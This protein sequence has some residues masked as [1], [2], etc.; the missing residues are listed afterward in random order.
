VA[1]WGGGMSPVNRK[2]TTFNWR[3]I[4]DKDTD[5]DDCLKLGI[6][7]LT[8][9]S[10]VSLLLVVTVILNYSVRHKKLHPFYSYN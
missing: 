1:V 6:I 9:N 3:H 8:R 2:I 7:T 4:S 10:D 5:N